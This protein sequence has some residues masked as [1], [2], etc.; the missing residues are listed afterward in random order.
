MLQ[1]S[2]N[3]KKKVLENIKCSSIDAADVSFPN[4]IDS[5]VLKMKKINFM[6]KLSDSFKETFRQ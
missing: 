1:L 5:I 6:D 3:N 2:K 4:L